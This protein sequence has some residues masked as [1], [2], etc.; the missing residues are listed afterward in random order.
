MGRNIKIPNPKG[1]KKNAY[2][3]LQTPWYRPPEGSGLKPRSLPRT[4]LGRRASGDF[5]AHV[6]PQGAQTGLTR[7]AI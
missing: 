5:Y 2:Q 7:A 6:P 1:K 3:H 4:A